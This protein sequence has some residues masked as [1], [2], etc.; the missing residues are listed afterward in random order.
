MSLKASD[1]ARLLELCAKFTDTG[2]MDGTFT[3]P[4][5]GWDLV[6]SG[7]VTEDK[8][9]TTAGRAAL[10]L[11]G[12]GHDPFPE[13]KEYQE[14]RIPLPSKEEPTAPPA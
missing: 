11:M 10:F 1:Q 14:F 5:C 12:K 7:L 13:S 6:R 3:Y 2:V 8:K 4:N 9:V